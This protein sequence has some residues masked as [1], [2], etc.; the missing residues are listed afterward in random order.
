MK[1]NRKNA[2]PKST[3]KKLRYSRFNANRFLIKCGA[4][5]RRLGG[6]GRR[7]WSWS[8]WVTIDV[9]RGRRTWVHRNP[10]R[11]RQH[12]AEREHH[13][14]GKIVHSMRIQLAREISR[15]NS[16]NPKDKTS[17]SMKK[18]SSARKP[19]PISHNQAETELQ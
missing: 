19:R 2:D 7:R 14:K 3:T 15:R 18:P 10:S 11:I 4:W 5:G 1:A 6:G 12:Q 13:P 16:K 8:L 17:R 9:E